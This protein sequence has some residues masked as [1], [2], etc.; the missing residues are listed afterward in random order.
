MHIFLHYLTFAHRLIS[1][2]VTSRNKSISTAL[3]LLGPVIEER[4]AKADELGADWEGKPA[5]YLPMI[6]CK[7]W[8]LRTSQND[9]ISWLLEDAIG[10][11]RTVHNLVLRVLSTN[12]AALHTTSMVSSPPNSNISAVH[13][14]CLVL[15]ADVHPRDI[16]SD[17]AAGAHAAVA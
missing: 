15:S 6:E 1:R 4:L 5:S 12:F 17:D 3:K 9:F 10:E 13:L 2:F 16:R 14:Y 11:E 8:V 7:N